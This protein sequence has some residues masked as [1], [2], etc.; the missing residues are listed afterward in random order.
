MAAVFTGASLRECQLT[1]H[2]I[3]SHIDA[4]KRSTVNKSLVAK[5]LE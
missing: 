5:L 1:T 3:K 2:R 4:F